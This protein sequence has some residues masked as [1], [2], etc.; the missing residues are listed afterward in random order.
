VLF[1]HR[2]VIQWPLPHPWAFNDSVEFPLLQCMQFNGP[3]AA[4]YTLNSPNPAHPVY[5]TNS[6]RS[7]IVCGRSFHCCKPRAIRAPNNIP[8]THHCCVRHCC[9]HQCCVH[10]CCVH[11]C[12]VRHCCVRHCCVHHCC[13]HH[14]YVRHCCVHHCCVR[15]CCVHHCCVRHCCVH[16][17]CVHHCCV[18]HCCVQWSGLRAASCSLN[19]SPGIRQVSFLKAC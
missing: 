14:C 3:Q 5:L 18:H 7:S 8:S 16:H 4:S 2:S 10:H 15:H 6:S 12:C 17:C 9:V 11:H 1:T 13:V 19:N